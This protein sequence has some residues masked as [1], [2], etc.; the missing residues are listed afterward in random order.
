M[1]Q[2]FNNR[3]W[4]ENVHVEWVDRGARCIG[5]QLPPFLELPPYPINV[6]PR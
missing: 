3:A 6:Q 4:L 1:N 2:F 5:Y